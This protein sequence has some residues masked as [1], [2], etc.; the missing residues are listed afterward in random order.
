MSSD[1]VEK[2]QAMLARAG[3]AIQSTRLAGKP[4]PDGFADRVA[5]ACITAARQEIHRNE[6]G[7][8]GTIIDGALS[9][10]PD[11]P[12]LKRERASICVANGDPRAA[13]A[14]L[15]SVLATCADDADALHLAGYACQLTWR[16]NEAIA[17]L[18]RAVALRPEND[19]F[20]RTLAN[21]YSAAGRPQDAAAI[22]QRF[23][24]QEPECLDYL[25]YLAGALNDAGE[26]KQA[27]ETYRRIVRLNPDCG[28]AHRMAGLATTYDS[29]SHPHIAELE[30]GLTRIADDKTNAREFHFALYRAYDGAKDYDRAF[31]HLL[32]ANRLLG[33]TKGYSTGSEFTLIQRLQDHFSAAF[34][35]EMPVSDSKD[36]PIFIVG[37]PRSGSTLTEQILASHP[38]VGG[39]GEVTVLQDIVERD[40]FDHGRSTLKT[41]DHGSVPLLNALAMEYMSCLSGMSPGARRVTDKYLSNF[42]WVGVIRMLFPLARI[43]HCRRDPVANGFSIFSNHF[44]TSGLLYKTRLED[45]GR[46]HRAYSGLMAHW[47]DRFPGWIHDLDYEAL[48]ENQ[49]EE[50]RRLL[51]YCG[52]AWDPACLEFHKTKRTVRTTSYNQVRKAMYSGA[53]R[54]TMNYIRHLQPLIDS[55]SAEK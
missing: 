6:P 37:L 52:L 42:L 3:Q 5:E 36:S 16:L 47:H 14:H 9:L 23:A 25:F 11:H 24:E 30:D 33:E 17:H 26:I 7:A 19:R 48:T 1:T 12:A 8:A 49:E 28:T 18:Q 32:E 13:L 40:L 38:D 39:A 55:L 53:D 50:T 4:L 31:A 51:A 34:V 15:S 22:W 10:F 21:A 44:E 2:I 45:I 35:E 27:A 29:P 41:F 20:H 54:K 46:Y 43:V